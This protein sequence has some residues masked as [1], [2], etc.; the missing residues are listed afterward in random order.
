MRC[1]ERR[2]RAVKTLIWA[3]TL[4]AL[5]AACFFYYP[6]AFTGPVICPMP[7]MTGVPCPGC[8]ITRAFSLATHGHFAEA[9]AFHP[10]WIPLLAYFALL[11]IYKIVEEW[12]GRP[13]RLD[14]Y[15]VSAY[16]ILA[17]LW[18]WALRLAFFFAQGGLQAVARDNVFS[19]L[20]R[21]F[22]F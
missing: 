6:Y 7:L 17:V 1:P 12:R 14:T 3:S 22:G 2:S 18:F 19:R 10:L 9:Y 21:A 16:A 5:L 13:P 8:G 15:R 11:W 20:W 4:P